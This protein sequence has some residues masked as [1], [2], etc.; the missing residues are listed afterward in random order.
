MHVV[1]RLRRAV[2]VLGATALVASPLLLL[3]PPG[4]TASGT[5]ATSQAAMPHIKA[6]LTK[7]A[8]R[9]T[10]A[11]ALRAGR[12]RLSVTG[13]GTVEFAMFKAGYDVADF[14]RDVNKY[15]AKNDI[16][17]LRRALANT[18]ILGGFAGGGSGTIVFPRAGAYTPFALGPRGV[19]T[20]R[21][22]VVRGPARSTRPPRTDGTIIGKN[23]PSWGGSS[24]LPA[25][26]RFLFKNKRN[27]G[28]PHFVALQQVEQG[29]TV[30]EVLAFLQSGE[31]PPPAWMLPGSYETGSISPGH[32]LTADYD[33]PPGQY[34]V[35][36]FFPDP[37]MKG[38]PHSLMGMI[39]MI[40]LV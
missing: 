31:G 36:C 8:V 11:D 38:M 34:A 28:V 1:K 27:T 30:E 2:A 39:K 26:G 20:G 35:L 16:K 23:G 7:K 10:G 13:Q 17:A 40:Q 25:K 24:Q 3:S 19:V 33:L 15:G 37:S 4:A 21:T 22:V 6:R 29:T 9:L 12:V 14:T 18:Q 5:T 32:D